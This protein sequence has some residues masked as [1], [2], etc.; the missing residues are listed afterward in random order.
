MQICLPVSQLMLE[1]VGA[2]PIFP[3][4]TPELGLEDSF[5]QLDDTLI[6]AATKHLR[7]EVFDIL[8]APFDLRKKYLRG[9]YG[10]QGDTA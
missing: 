5:V 3:A 1:H 8:E 2:Q 6:D 4:G 9:Q 7:A 10:I